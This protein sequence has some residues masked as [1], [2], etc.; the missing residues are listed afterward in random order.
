MRNLVQDSD[1]WMAWRDWAASGVS[2]AFD[3]QLQL[4]EAPHL[5]GLLMIVF[6]RT[7]LRSQ[8]SASVHRPHFCLLVVVW[9]AVCLSVCRSAWLSLCLSVC[10]LACFL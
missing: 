1:E 4:L 9:F 2:M 3:G 6:V 10:L 8:V 7:S 5:V